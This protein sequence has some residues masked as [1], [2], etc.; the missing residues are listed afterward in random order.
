[1]NRTIVLAFLDSWTDI[2]VLAVLQELGN[3]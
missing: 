1:M 2:I 3:Y